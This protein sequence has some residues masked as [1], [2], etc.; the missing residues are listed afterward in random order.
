MFDR[1]ASK[2]DNKHEDRLDHNRIMSK[3][4]EQEMPEL[5]KA[6]II[7]LEKHHKAFD[8]SI[9]DIDDDSETF[10]TTG[11]SGRQGQRRRDL[12]K[13]AQDKAKERIWQS[14]EHEVSS[15]ADSS[16]DSDEDDH[17]IWL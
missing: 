17:Q 10:N 13:T 16:S 5:T 1:K 12:K 8:T 6:S 9:D 14:I 11:S 4:Y 15:Q 7:D 3:F 2:N